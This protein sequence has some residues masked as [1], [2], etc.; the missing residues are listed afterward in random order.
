MGQ[1]QSELQA[2][3]I[4]PPQAERPE[5]KAERDLHILSEEKVDG[6]SL[7]TLLKCKPAINN[8]K[9]ITY[10]HA[11]TILNHLTSMTY[12]SNVIYQTF[13]QFTLADGPPNSSKLF[14]IYYTHNV[15]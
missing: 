10:V 8:I 9:A 3:S 5:K 13:N 6:N 15:E 7:I 11:D 1:Q 2:N 14:L 4:S 12:I